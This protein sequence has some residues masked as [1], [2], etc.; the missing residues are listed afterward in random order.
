[1]RIYTASSEETLRAR[2]FLSDWAAEGCISQPQYERLEQETVSGLRT[3]N[4]YLRIIL[5]LFTTIVVAATGGLSF[6]V[7]LS[8]PSNQTTGFFLLIFAAVCYAAAEVTVSRARLYRHGIEEAPLICSVGFLCLGMELAFFSSRP[9]SPGPAAIEY[10]VPAAG[11]LLSLWIWH[12]FGYSYAFLAA[13]VFVVFLPGYWTSSHAAERLSIVAFYAI[14]LAG[15]AAVRSRHHFDYLEDHYSLAEAFLWLGIYLTVNLRLLSLVPRPLWWAA[16]PPTPEFP[17][18]FYWTTWVLIWCLPLVV[19]VRG[20]R[21]K[22]RFVIA[23]GGII[24]V[25]TLV[26]NKP[27][28][29]WP[30]H[31]WDPMI[32]GVVLTAV[33]LLLRRWL[34]SGPNG[35]RHGFTAARISARD[36][37]V[38]NAASAALGLVSAPAVTASHQAPRHGVQFEGGRSGGGGASGSY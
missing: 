33:A 12:R 6:L 30:R 21:L 9:Y 37:Q 31:T 8:L 34:S 14:G 19:L 38:A 18:P 25:L 29:G 13:M 23:T 17:K 16:A 24:V 22:D 26:S 35:I 4:I 5:F 1:M 20:I 11:A 2:E 32:L 15:V 10:L 36:R 28:L 3:T 27:Y 7:F